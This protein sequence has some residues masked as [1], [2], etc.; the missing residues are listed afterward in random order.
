MDDI[1]TIVI[2]GAGQAGGRCAEQLFDAHFKGRIVLIGDELYEP[3]E[4]PALSKGFM[5]GG[6]EL[7]D[8]LIRQNGWYVTEGIDLRL[9]TRVDAIDRAKRQ[10]LL[11]KGRET[12]AYDRLVI[13]TG[14]RPYI[15]KPSRGDDSA[16]HYLRTFDD[17][18]ALRPKLQ[19]C[20]RIGIIGGGLLG[21]EL[22]AT[23]TRMG[24]LVT[25]VE[26]AEYP[27]SR[28]M[29]AQV[30]THMIDLHRRN[31]VEL[32]LNTQVTGLTADEDGAQV[33]LSNGQTLLLET[34][35]VAIGVTPNI[36]LAKTAGLTIADGGVLTDEFGRTSDPHI[37]AIGD[38]VTQQHPL[39]HRWMRLQNS[40]AAHFHACIVANNLLRQ[41][42]PFKEVPWISTQQ[43]GVGIQMLGLPSPNDRFVW[44]EHPAAGPSIGFALNGDRLT[45]AYTFNSGRELKALRVIIE[46]GLPVRAEQ[47][48]MPH[49][50]LAELTGGLVKAPSMRIRGV[51]DLDDDSDDF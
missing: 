11:D 19:N 24:C 9:G 47:L 20:D 28:V 1:Q 38:V 34:L 12:I 35:I 18:L 23:A 14:S 32:L 5:T 33:T 26:P 45:A 37:Y 4:R 43:F 25:V 39:L 46:K 48:Q 51:H 42:I 3:Y 16:I 44:R 40:I 2:I 36:E 15:L 49:F 31:G 6:E 7:E 8:M 29:P 17:A 27:M 30:A 50:R 10:V 22:A 13:A 41:P 21:M